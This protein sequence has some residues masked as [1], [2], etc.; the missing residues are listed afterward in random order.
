MNIL[1]VASAFTE[2]RML[3]GAGFK[4]YSTGVNLIFKIEVG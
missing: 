1:E 2:S 3:S 4:A